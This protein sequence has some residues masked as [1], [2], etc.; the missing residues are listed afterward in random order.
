M[1]SSALSLDW[2]SYYVGFTGYGSSYY[3]AISLWQFN[4]SAGDTIDKKLFNTFASS[5][6]LPYSDATVV[7]TQLQLTAP[8]YTSV[9][10]AIHS[11]KLFSYLGFQSKFNYIATSCTNKNASLRGL[12][13][14][15]V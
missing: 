12:P 4:S 3:P 11:N 9:G 10:A 1:H 13:E 15:Y 8:N 7:P 6:F 14:G 5:D 2:E